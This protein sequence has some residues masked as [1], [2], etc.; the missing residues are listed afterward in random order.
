MNDKPTDDT[1]KKNGNSDSDGERGE[2]CHQDEAAEGA[3]N[4]HE[5]R[6]PAVVIFLRERSPVCNDV[7]Q[8]HTEGGET[9]SGTKIDGEDE[10]AD[11]NGERYLRMMGNRVNGMNGRRRGSGGREGRKDSGA[12][13]GSQAN[14]NSV[15]K[16]QLSCEGAAC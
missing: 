5:L 16:P 13:H 14:D 1:N 6:I 11:D 2:R 8:E 4:L 10:D 3:D 12:N 15:A 7:I 9:K